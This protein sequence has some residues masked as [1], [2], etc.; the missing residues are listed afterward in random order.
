MSIIKLGENYS[1]INIK[2]K[3]KSFALSLLNEEENIF[4]VFVEKF[5]N[6][7]DVFIELLNFL[8]INTFEFYENNFP[9]YLD[10]LTIKSNEQGNFFG[11]LNKI[12]FNVE[13]L[14]LYKEEVLLTFE[15]IIEKDEQ[16]LSTLYEMFPQINEY[17][18]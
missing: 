15:K 9:K 17:L 4:L 7:S 1:D 5:R 13:N 16:I 2:Y 14:K 3:L 18:P 12:D 11:I 6:N 8:K 10:I